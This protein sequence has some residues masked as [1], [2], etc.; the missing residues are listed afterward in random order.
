ML[1]RDAALHYTYRFQTE[2]L[3]WFHTAKE[4][5]V[6]AVYA[7]REVSMSSRF[8]LFEKCQC[9]RGLCCSRSV[10]VIAVYTVRKVLT[11][12]AVIPSVTRGASSVLKLVTPSPARGKLGHLHLLTR[13]GV[14][15]INVCVC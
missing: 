1:T 2:I 14:S 12:L 15:V 3:Y 10:N 8:M 13:C 7:V 9:R 4:V 5:N 11:S 6:I